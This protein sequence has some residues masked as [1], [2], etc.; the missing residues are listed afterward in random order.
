MPIAATVPGA[1]SARAFKVTG[2]GKVP[3]WMWAEVIQ[4]RGF[5]LEIRIPIQ[6]SGAPDRQKKPVT[7]GCHERLRKRAGP[8]SSRSQ[9]CDNQKSVGLAGL[10]PATSCTQSRRASQAALQPVPRKV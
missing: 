5:L 9:G 3:V 6:P 7:E 2:T 10:E 1:V 8:Q 4:G